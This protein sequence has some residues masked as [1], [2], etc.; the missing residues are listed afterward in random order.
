[1]SEAESSVPVEMMLSRLDKVRKNGKRGWVACCPA[2]EDKTV[3]LSVCEGAG[4][5]VLLNCFAGCT[6]LDV[7]HALG[8]ELHE[9]F[10]QS[11]DKMTKEERAELHERGMRTKWAAALGVLD[12]ESFVVY[13]VANKLSMG[14]A[15]TE[16]T[17]KRLSI[18]AK[19]IAEARIVLKTGPAKRRLDSFRVSLPGEAK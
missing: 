12:R 13:M 7:V 10:P 18:A 19:R 6:A 16:P 9:L 5:R 15:V 11:T 14:G 1:M 3:S 4:G 17:R 8:M 2:H